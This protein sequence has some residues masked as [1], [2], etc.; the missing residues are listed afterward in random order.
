MT[1]KSHS[2]VVNG[3]G[4]RASRKPRCGTVL[5]VDDDPLVRHVTSHLVKAAGSA[6]LEASGGN[7]ALS[8]LQT[9]Q[10]DLII[11]DCHMPD[12]D[13]Y[14]TA[15]A[16]R[17]VEATS[18]FPHQPPGRAVPI[19][20]LTADGFESNRVRCFAAGMSDFLT[21]PASRLDILECLVTW[22]GADDDGGE[23]QDVG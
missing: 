8:V 2:E 12:L 22:L 14:G 11:M 23:Q 20:A 7:E 5:V 13:G 4:V 9:Q 21:K 3:S 18:G 6:V 16:I 15:E 19:V 17:R 1:R 10:V